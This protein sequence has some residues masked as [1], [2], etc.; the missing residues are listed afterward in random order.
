M[1]RPERQKYCKFILNCW[2]NGVAEEGCFYILLNTKIVLLFRGVGAN[3]DSYTLHIKLYIKKK[4]IDVSYL[5]FTDS[6]KR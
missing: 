2:G 1:L 5:S 4:N 6:F 3:G